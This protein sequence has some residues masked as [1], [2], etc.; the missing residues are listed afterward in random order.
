MVPY[1]LEQGRVVEG[2]RVDRARWW[3]V[4]RSSYLSTLHLWSWGREE[5]S[6]TFFSQAAGTAVTRSSCRVPEW[7]SVASPSF[8]LADNLL[9]LQLHCWL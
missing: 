6:G 2:A 4:H 5:D 3:R 7:V 1:S 9:L 8:G